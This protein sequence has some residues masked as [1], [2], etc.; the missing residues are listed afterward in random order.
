MYTSIIVKQYTLNFFSASFLVVFY[1]INTLIPGCS[2][3]Y[4]YTLKNVWRSWNNGVHMIS[5]GTLCDILYF[6]Y[7]H[8]RTVWFQKRV[9]RRAKSIDVSLK[10]KLNEL[11]VNEPNQKS[12]NPTSATVWWMSNLSI[13]FWNVERTAFLMFKAHTGSFSSGHTVL[14]WPSWNENLKKIKKL[15]LLPTI[16]ILVFYLEIQRFF[17][18]N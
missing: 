17:L 6:I 16:T 15:H 8:L 14:I 2:T 10:I 13:R 9:R 11:I 5:F 3:L 18:A 7:Y 4:T 1:Y 12:F